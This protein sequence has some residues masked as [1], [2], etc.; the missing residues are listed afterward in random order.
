MK[1]KK[2]GAWSFVILSA[3]V[4][5]SSCTPEARIPVAGSAS[6]QDM[7]TLLPSDTS[8][9]MVLDWNKIVHLPRFRAM[10]E[11]EPELQ[12][13]QKKIS[14]FVDLNKDVYFLAL[15]I[16]G[17]VKK[18]AENA[19]MLVN[20]KY[21]EEKLLPAETEKDSTLEYYEGVPFFP[22]VEIEESAVICTAFLD[23]SNLAIGSEKSIKKI[24]DVYK[25]KTSNILSRKDIK[26]YLKDINTKAMTFSFISLPPELL[27][28]A[29][30]QNPQFKMW[31]NLRYFSAFSDYRNKLYSAEIKL[32]AQDKTQHQKMAENL[33]GLKALALGLAGEFPEI[34]QV[35]NAL[36]ITS[37]DQYVKIYL[38]L[39]DEIIDQLAKALKER[40]KDLPKGKGIGI[41][42]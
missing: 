6:G 22:M 17:D 10:L 3:L 26:T 8:A 32:Y 13:Y 42:I 25:K 40:T 23:S 9:F 37:T 7:L 31:D 39:K 33:I 14:S 18:A 19:V 35:L 11:Q 36:E 27:N 16:T 30:A 5:L 21:Q 38:S 34:T 28:Q 1:I 12:P 41:G 24:I 15:A 20:L 2:L 4:I 29:A